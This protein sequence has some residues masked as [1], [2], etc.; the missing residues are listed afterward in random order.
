MRLL[1]YRRGARTAQSRRGAILQVQRDHLIFPLD[2]TKGVRDE[3]HCLKPE[4]PAFAAL[5]TFA[6]DMASC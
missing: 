3:C 6:Q 2:R 1:A 5:T 4:V